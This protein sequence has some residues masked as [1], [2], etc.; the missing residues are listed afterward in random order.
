VLKVELLQEAKA[1]LFERGFNIAE[2]ALVD[3]LNQKN[4]S[5]GH[6]KNH[7]ANM[8]SLLFIANGGPLLWQHFSKWRENQPQNIQHPLDTYTKNTLKDL[9]VLIGSKGIATD[10]IFPFYQE[11]VWFNFQNLAEGINLTRSSPLGLHLHPVYGPWVSF[12][13]LLLLEQPWEDGIA[14]ATVEHF[15]PCPS[16]PKPCISTCPAQALTTAGAD[17]TKCYTYRLTPAS[18]CV[19]RCLARE[20]CPVGK[21][22]QFPRDAIAFHYRLAK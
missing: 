13:G 8:R 10:L 1:F 11:K 7:Y 4:K 6:L 3:R 21:E 9:Q 19:D 17:I 12:R 22:H 14:P 16:C 5:V 2:P 20:A 18:P 15:D